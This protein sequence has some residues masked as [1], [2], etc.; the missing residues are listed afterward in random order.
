MK[1]IYEFKGKGYSAREIA[2]SLGLARNTVLRYLNDPEAIVPKAR[3][4][5]GSKLDAHVDYIDGRMGEGLENCVV[6]LRELRALV[7]QRRV[8]G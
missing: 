5:R 1:E 2:R 6:L 7:L 8:I 3:A 4:L